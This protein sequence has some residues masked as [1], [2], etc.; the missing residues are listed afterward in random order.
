MENRNCRIC[1][2]VYQ[3]TGPAQKWCM[4]CGVIERKRRLERYEKSSTHPCQDCGVPVG[5]RAERCSFCDQEHRIGLREGPDSGNWKGGRSLD[6]HGYVHVLIP[7]EE[8]KGRRYRAEHMVVWE[9]ANGKPVPKGWIVHHLNGV[10][11]DN[12]LEN[13]VGLP[14][15]EHSSWTLVELAQKRIRELEQLNGHPNQ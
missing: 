4:A 12:R 8:R 7:R 3:P 14:R 9:K 2:T 5:R 15:K 6:K 13:L 1:G 10:R 11:D